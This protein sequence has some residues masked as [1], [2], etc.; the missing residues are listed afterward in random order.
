MALKEGFSGLAACA[1]R[2]E[3]EMRGLTSSPQE[4]TTGRIIFMTPSD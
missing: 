2:I 4:R 3:C 1:S